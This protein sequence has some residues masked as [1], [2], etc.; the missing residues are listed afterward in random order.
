MDRDQSVSALYNLQGFLSLAHTTNCLGQYAGQIFPTKDDARFIMPGMETPVTGGE[1]I[2]KFLADE[3]FLRS[4]ATFQWIHL[5]H[6]PA[7]VLD[8]QGDSA[9]VTWD[10][11][12]YRIDRSKKKSATCTTRFSAKCLL[13]PQ[14]W[15]LYQVDWMVMQCFV[16]EEYGEEQMP[17]HQYQP[18]SAG[19][20]NTAVLA[21]VDYLSIRNVNNLVVLRNW[22]EVEPLFSEH[23]VLYAEGIAEKAFFGRSGVAEFCN[24]IHEQESVHG[25]RYRCLQLLG[26]GYLTAG[27]H[28]AKGSWLSE[29]FE[30]IPNEKNEQIIR[31]RICRLDQKFERSEQGWLLQEYHMMTLFEL[32]DIYGESPLY[33]RMTSPL[34]NW[35]PIEYDP[36]CVRPNACFEVENLYALWPACLRRGELMTYLREHMSGDDVTCKLSI[37]SRG[38]ETPT[39]VGFEAIAGK[40]QGMDDIAVLSLPSYHCATTPVLESSADGNTVRASWMDHSLTNMSV[41]LGA[42][43]ENGMVPYMIFVSRYDHVFRRIHNR[44]YL[45][46]FGWEPALGLP[47][48]LCNPADEIGWDPQRRGLKYPRPVLPEAL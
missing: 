2:R 21:A 44:W 33:Q 9:T 29:T 25:G 27:E 12:S 34:G 17:E 43:P 18:W 30:V 19:E 41:A 46:E 22:N 28:S 3:Q 32:P 26:P 37:R 45:V 23:A 39:L 11:Y 40:L 5:F 36:R 24:M 35:I 10:T 16:P 1:T 4:S 15:R 14:G 48:W 47:N 6:T 38:P 42:D 31:R 8:E 7:V 13:E 20:D